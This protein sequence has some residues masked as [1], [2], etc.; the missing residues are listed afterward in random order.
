VGTGLRIV[1]N[2]DISNNPASDNGV[3]IYTSG[4]TEDYLVRFKYKPIFPAGV[5]QISAI[6]QVGVYPNPTSGLVYVG[7]T[8]REAID[9]NLAILSVTGATLQ[10]KSFSAGKGNFVTELD[11][12][13]FAKGTYMLKISSKQ[14]NFVRRVVVE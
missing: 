13:G 2:N 8:I 1:L 14:G 6:Q 11:M 12:S 4:E 5:D 10:E 9:F 3:G 7:L